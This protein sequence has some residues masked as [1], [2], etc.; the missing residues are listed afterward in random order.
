M[1]PQT[2]DGYIEVVLEGGVWCAAH[3]GPDGQPDPLIVDLFDT[4]VIPTPY[5][6]PTTRATVIERLRGR[7][8]NVHA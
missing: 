3:Y 1:S 8:N 2:V 5:Y 4:H 6:L 7:G